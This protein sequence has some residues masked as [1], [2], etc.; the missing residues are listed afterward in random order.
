MRRAQLPAQ[1]QY[2]RAERIE[3]DENQSDRILGAMLDGLFRGLGFERLYAPQ[4]QAAAQIQP[5]PRFTR[6]DQNG[7]GKRR[8]ETRGESRQHRM[9]R[10]A[11]REMGLRAHPRD[12]RQPRPKLQAKK[13]HA[14]VIPKTFQATLLR[15]RIILVHPYNAPPD[16]KERS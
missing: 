9:A 5:L 10:L 3:I 1:R 6:H 12:L 16:N 11:F 4:A 14:G 7:S 15:L 2:L 13:S 8:I